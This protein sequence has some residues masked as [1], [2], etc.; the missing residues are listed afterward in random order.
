MKN[1]KELMDQLP[2]KERTRPNNGG[3][4][5]PIENIER[6]LDEIYDRMWSSEWV[7]APRFIAPNVM[8]C[9]LNVIV[10]EGENWRPMAGTASII[11][12]LNSLGHPVPEEVV[13][14]DKIIK[15]LAITNAAREYGGALGRYLNRDK[16]RD[17]SQHKVTVVNS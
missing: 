11:I 17:E 10:L 1:Y 9:A 5:I 2:P 8:S 13:H 6:I 16:E 15:S 3:Y 14:A 4:Y 12:G 7:E